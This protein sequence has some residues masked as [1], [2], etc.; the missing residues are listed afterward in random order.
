M[1]IHLSKVRE[2][3]VQMASG[4]S[5]SSDIMVFFQLQSNASCYVLSRFWEV[6]LEDRASLCTIFRPSFLTYILREHNFLFRKFSNLQ[7]RNL[8]DFEVSYS[9][10][11]QATLSQIGWF[12]EYVLFLSFLTVTYKEKIPETL[13]APTLIFLKN[14][15]TSYQPYR[16]ALYSNNSALYRMLELGWGKYVNKQ[17]RVRDWIGSNGCSF[18]A[19]CL[20]PGE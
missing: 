9:C 16:H 15:W 2:Y 6:F 4:S 20:R 5:S 19:L 13:P 8:L 11:W 1:W 17:R 18:V 14:D 7:S 3:G 12:H 10:K